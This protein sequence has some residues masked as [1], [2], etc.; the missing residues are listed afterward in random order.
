MDLGL[1]SKMEESLHFSSPAVTPNTPALLTE[2]SVPGSLAPYLLSDHIDLTDLVTLDTLNSVKHH[3][4]YS[5]SSNTNHH[6]VFPAVMHSQPAFLPSFPGETESSGGH[7][8]SLSGPDRV[9]VMNLMS[10]KRNQSEVRI[11]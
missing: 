8:E 4:V 3:D 6:A 11:M 10:G 7:R 1:P 2:T 9:S 5:P